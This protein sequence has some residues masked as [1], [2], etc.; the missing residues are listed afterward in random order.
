LRTADSRPCHCR[1][2][3]NNF[4]LLRIIMIVCE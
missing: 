4:H 1:R 3:K 2:Q